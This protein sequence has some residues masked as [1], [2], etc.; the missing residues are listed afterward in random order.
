M[1]S[2]Y[3]QVMKNPF[4]VHELE[5]N[6]DVKNIIAL[7]DRFYIRKAICIDKKNKYGK[8]WRITDFGEK[9]LK[10]YRKKFLSTTEDS[11]SSA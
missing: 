6:E 4:Q 1:N 8:T 9:M 10:K 3:D 2:I 5:K 7:K 11:A